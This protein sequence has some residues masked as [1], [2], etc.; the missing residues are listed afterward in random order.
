MV[1]TGLVVVLPRL[2][3]RATIVFDDRCIVVLSNPNDEFDKTTVVHCAL[4]TG[5][6][7]CQDNQHAH[8][9]NA[10]QPLREYV[11]MFA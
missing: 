11:S 8:S 2:M 7:V 9:A 6:C 1:V 3:H 4:M 5:L 10:V